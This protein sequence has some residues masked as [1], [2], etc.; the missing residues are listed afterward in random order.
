MKLRNSYISLKILA[1]DLNIP[2]TVAKTSSTLSSGKLTSME[3]K[4]IEIF[5]GDYDIEKVAASSTFCDNVDFV[6]DDEKTTITGKKSTNRVR[7]LKK[8][9]LNDNKLIKLRNKFLKRSK[10]STGLREEKSNLDNDP[11]RPET[12]EENQ[13][14]ENECPIR[15]TEQIIGDQSKLLSPNRN[16]VKMGTRVFS[17]QFLNKSYDNI[18][19]NAMDLCQFDDADELDEPVKGRKIFPKQP[20]VKS[21]FSD[22][23]STSDDGV[24]MKSS[25]MS[26]LYGSE[27]QEEKLTESVMPSE[28]YVIRKYFS[29]FFF[30]PHA[31]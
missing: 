7:N 13:N 11:A 10:S 17:A 24:S 20:R 6:A 4:K 22:I 9:M 16:R 1:H 21:H 3:N 15:Q 29:S 28:A 12:L 27:K 14:K 8:S 25:S 30:E 5:P 23:D 26:S 18:Y 31:N 19:D 2:L